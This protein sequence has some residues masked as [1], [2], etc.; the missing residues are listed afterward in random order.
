MFVKR[1]CNRHHAFLFATSMPENWS[2]E[3][4]HRL[5]LASLR[6][7]APERDG[8]RAVLESAEHVLSESAMQQN[9]SAT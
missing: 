6:R 5:D 9:K 7:D 4:Q 8:A 2:Q 3:R 1:L